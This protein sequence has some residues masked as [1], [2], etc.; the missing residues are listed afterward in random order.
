MSN[1]TSEEVDK[2]FQDGSE[3]FDFEFKESSW[4]AMEGLLD[5]RDRKRWFIWW[6]VGLLFGIG[7]LSIGLSYY[8]ETP[9]IQVSPK[10]VDKIQNTNLEK[11]LVEE[12]LEQHKSDETLLNLKPTENAISSEEAYQIEDA[13]VRSKNQSTITNFK[14]ID[15]AE[16]KEVQVQDE[17]LIDNDKVRKYLQVGVTQSE[18]PPSNLDIEELFPEKIAKQNKR[19]N[20]D[21]LVTINPS[22]IAIPKATISFLPSFQPKI[23]TDSFSIIDLDPLLLNNRWT[24]QDNQRTNYFT[25]GLLLGRELSFVQ[26]TTLANTNWKVGLNLGYRYNDKLALEFGAAYSIKDYS[27]DG[28][29]YT[30]PKGFWTRAIAPDATSGQCDIL[31]LTISQSYFFK[32]Y[33]QRGFYASIGLTSYLM[34]REQYE[35][36]YEIPD[37]ELRQAWQTRND[38]KHW[39]GIGEVSIGYNLPLFEHSSMQIATYA[40]LPL[41]GI[42]HGELRLF[43]SGMVVRYNFHSR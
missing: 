30:A 31:E 41:T 2:L 5:R 1:F 16:E 8:A 4:E 11:E 17:E 33:Q 18:N 32:G 43:S 36:F 40:H 39:F 24:N 26:P 13:A 35:Y 14:P 42:G 15:E 21:T 20:I 37:P 3:N 7:I 34:L 23:E 9:Q 28:D 27:A 38:N 29:S 25:F 6:L 22:K 10:V 12:K 19:T